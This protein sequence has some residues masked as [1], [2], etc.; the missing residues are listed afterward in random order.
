[1]IKP[2]ANVCYCNKT[3]KGLM[4]WNTWILHEMSQQQVGQ[5]FWCKPLVF[6]V[7]PLSRKCDVGPVM[8]VCTTALKQK[9]NRSSW[10]LVWYSGVRQQSSGVKLL[11][12]TCLL[13]NHPSRQSW[14]LPNREPELTAEM[15]KWPNSDPHSGFLHLT[16]LSQHPHFSC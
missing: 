9:I 5:T 8:D 3:K 11:H 13:Q 1:M 16:A 6:L 2:F 7:F 15:R 12:E 14:L 4:G 10:V